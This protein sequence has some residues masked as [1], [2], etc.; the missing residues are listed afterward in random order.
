LVVIA[1]RVISRASDGEANTPGLSNA[2][3]KAVVEQDP[4]RLQDAH[5]PRPTSLRGR[6]L[7][8][9]EKRVLWLAGQGYG[10]KAIAHGLGI[11]EQTVKNAMSGACHKLGAMTRIGALYRMGWIVLPSAADLD[12]V[13]VSLDVP[14]RAHELRDSADRLRAFANAAGAAAALL[15]EAAGEDELGSQST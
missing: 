12:A 6:R 5:R 9:S 11:S 7:S 8:P 10:N 3:S 1:E 2:F 13:D 4:S 15:E 14:S